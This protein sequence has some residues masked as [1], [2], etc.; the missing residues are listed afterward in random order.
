MK[1]ILTVSIVSAL[2]TVLPAKAQLQFGFKGGINVTEMS[3]DENV[4]KSSNRLGY[5]IGPTVKLGLPITGIGIDISGLYEKKTTKVN[6]KA[7]DQENIIVPANIRLNIGEVAGVYLAAGPQFAFN[8]GDDEFKWNKDGVENTFQ[9][10]KSYLSINLG[11]G[12]FFSKHLEVGF[13][14]NIGVSNTGEAS[15]SEARHAISDDTKA[16]GWS[17]MGALYF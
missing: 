11:A 3:F 1:K 10:K 12:I 6:G 7:I 16:K 14:Y 2:L 15:W 4:F 5:F 17:V 13:V 9:L 8:I